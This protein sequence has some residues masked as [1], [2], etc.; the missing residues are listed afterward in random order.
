MRRGVDP[1]L[2]QITFG[3]LLALVPASSIAAEER[4]PLF[5]GV[6]V[7]EVGHGSAGERAGIEPGDI[8]LEWLRAANPPGN[9]GPASGTFRSAFDVHEVELEQSY[10]GSLAITLRRGDVTLTFVMP[11]FG[12]RDTAW[13]GD[14]WAI[15][16]RPNVVG[17]TLAAYFEA[18][19]FE[20]EGNLGSAT[21]AWRE[22]AAQHAGWG[23]HELAAWAYE[24][25]ARASG[26]IGCWEDATQLHA[27]AV[28]E[29]IRAGEWRL[30][31]Q[32][33]EAHAARVASNNDRTAL[34][35]VLDALS[36][37]RQLRWRH[38]PSS[39]ATADV[40]GDLGFTYLNASLTEDTGVAQTPFAKQQVTWLANATRFSQQALTIRE[41]LAPSS[42]PVIWSLEVLARTEERYSRSPHRLGGQDFARQAKSLRYKSLQIARAAFPD[43]LLLAYLLANRGAEASSRGE[44]DL[45]KQFAEQAIT[46]LNTLGF[47]AWG[48]GNYDEAV[49]PFTAS[50]R[51]AETLLGES[52]SVARPLRWLSFIAAKGNNLREAASFERKAVTILER[53]APGTQELAW[54]LDS[55]GQ[56]LWRLGD[57]ASAYDRLSRALGIEQ[58]LSM[59]NESITTLSSLGRISMDLENLDRAE[60]LFGQAL[61]LLENCAPEDVTQRESTLL[62]LGLLARQR[63]MHDA[64]DGRFQEMAF[65]CE[66]ASPDDA[67]C[68]A[69]A[70][71]MQGYA[72]EAK[73]DLHAAQ[74]VIERAYAIRQQQAPDSA[75][76]IGYLLKL[77]ELLGSQGQYRLAESFLMKALALTDRLDQ[78]PRATTLNVLASQRWSEGKFTEA[79]EYFRRAIEVVE[80]RRRQLNG[81]SSVKTELG[82]A[83]YRDFVETLIN[84]ASVS[85]SVPGQDLLA[86]L[87]RLRARSLLDDAS[88]TRPECRQRRA[89]GSSIAA[90]SDRP[91]LRDGP[92]RAV[93]AEP[94]ARCRKG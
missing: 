36:R 61:E 73:G 1:T 93:A 76:T 5:A 74:S 29:A 54:A 64:A 59:D 6:V 91:R 45:A 79:E 4:Q 72:F 67:D 53:L 87:E 62:E 39:L 78:G 18:S 48:K 23:S 27:E 9:P 38:E 28:G 89:S 34:A 40:L 15:T 70:L 35:V 81:G 55:L 82:A 14:S 26:L 51:I 44:R 65:L 83:Y 77:G 71:T 30:Q 13:S 3:A 41:Q 86:I 58:M 66:Q 68:L 11:P 10:R 84:L 42:R 8:L 31:A 19:G 69:S 49:A 57:L 43:S 80:V 25:A 75:D 46:M 21:A 90:R 17:K 12:P 37:A 85:Q 92:E 60:L 22:V 7:E 32:L 56:T 88:R 16:A 24:R 20:E 2:L 33:W 52:L 47:A 63:G 50:V 94:T